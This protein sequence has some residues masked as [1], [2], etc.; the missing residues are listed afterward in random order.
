M[1]PASQK[2]FNWLLKDKIKDYQKQGKSVTLIP[3]YQKVTHLQ[4]KIKDENKG[5]NYRQG[6]IPGE[7]SFL[8]RR[9]LRDFLPD[10]ENLIL[11][12]RA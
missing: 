1:K 9:D 5:V 6:A 3:G 4:E 8:T 7:N 2:D 12:N 11:E 10:L